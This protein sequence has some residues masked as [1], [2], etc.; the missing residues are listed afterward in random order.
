MNRRLLLTSI[1]IAFFVF[2]VFSIEMY[3]YGHNPRKLIEGERGEAYKPVVTVYGLYLVGILGAWFAKLPPLPIDRKNDSA[4]FGIAVTCTILFNLFVLYF[5]SLAH[6]TDQGS[7]E[8]I[9]N[10]MEYAGYFSILVAP[11]NL[12][13]F[14]VK[15]APAG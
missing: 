8:A 2:V 10:S 6:W 9:K 12:Y 5:V 11:V 15:S 13:Y 3:Y 14:S 1:W 4:R 7:L